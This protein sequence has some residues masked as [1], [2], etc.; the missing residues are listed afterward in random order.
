MLTTDD[1]TLQKSTRINKPHQKMVAQLVEKLLS[2]CCGD[3]E[4]LKTKLPWNKTN[5]D[6]DNDVHDSKPTNHTSKK[7]KFTDKEMKYEH[8]NWRNL[9]LKARRA[10]Q[11]VGFDQEKW[12]SGADDVSVFN[13]HWWDLKE[14]EQHAMEVLGWDEAAWEHKY[15]E[16]SWADLPS[17]VKK[18]AIAAGFD[19][20]T[21]DDDEWP[22]NLHMPWG[23][24]TQE[25][26]NAMTVLGWHEGKW[27]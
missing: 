25:D 16:T 24:L 21:W 11:D 18:A 12:D 22:D 15:E 2:V 3:N 23:E 26:R 8:S 17:H 9:P 4:F 27:D 20:D 13:K 19:E 5:H 14:K 7:S 6:D 10:A 1:I